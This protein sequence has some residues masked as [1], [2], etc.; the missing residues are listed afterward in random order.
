MRRLLLFACV[1]VISGIA[2]AQPSAGLVGHF[3]F[4]GNTTNT[5]SASMSA[6]TFNTPY[7]TNH[8]GAPNTAVQFAG[9]LTSYIDFV[10]NGNADFTGTNNFT[11]ACSFLF[12]GTGTGGLIDNCLNYGGW[13]IWLWST[14][15]GTWNIQF[16]YKNNSV[17][18]AAATAFTTGVWHHV[19]A[20]RNNGTIS[21]YI[22]GVHRL[23]ASEGTQAPSYPINMVAGAMAYG[24]YTPPRYNPFNGKMNQVT[25]YNRALSAAEIAALY[26]YTLPLKLKSFDGRIVSNSAEL[27]WKTADEMNVHS[28]DIERS[29]DGINYAAVGNVAAYNTPG[30]HQY[31]FSDSKIN[32]LGAPV[33]YYRLKQK[34][35]DD[36]FTYSGIVALSVDLSKNIVMFYPNPVVDDANLTITVN[37]KQH[38]QARIIDNTGRLIKSFVWSISAGSTSMP[39]DTR[40]LAKG[41][42]RLELKGESINETRQFVKQ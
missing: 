34:D 24:G 10:D 38:V 5:G 36:R 27:N 35:I 40:G 25:I 26:A 31:K 22:D 33:I 12:T 11:V 20:V 1:I 8:L 7:T 16:N 23:S 4:N 15:A 39:I 30:D 28:F 18:S 42:Y 21:V 29:T 41:I 6:T 32:S 37:K 9:A 3:R 17:G 19:T 2:A 14:V 13:G